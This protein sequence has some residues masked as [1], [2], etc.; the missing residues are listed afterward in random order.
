MGEERGLFLGTYG[1]MY[2][3]GWAL[4]VK[5]NSRQRDASAGSSESGPWQVPGGYR[6]T[7]VPTKLMTLLVG[8][9]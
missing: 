1:L 3:D 9:D 6:E 4:V 2:W 8:G 7:L 5:D